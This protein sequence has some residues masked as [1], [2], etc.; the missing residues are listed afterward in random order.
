MQ[1]Q[2]TPR[3]TSAA[4]AALL[5]AVSLVPG[6]SSPRAEAAT[7]TISAP[8]VLVDPRV[9]RRLAVVADLTGSLEHTRIPRVRLADL[10]PLIGANENGGEVILVAVQSDADR[11]ALRLRVPRPPPSPS[12]PSLTGNPVRDLPI[13]RAHSRLLADVARAEDARVAARAAAV[14][15]FRVEAEALQAEPIHGESD[16]LGALG[17]IARALHEPAP[18]GWRPRLAE[19]REVLARLLDRGAVQ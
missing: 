19:V 17:R 12:L 7:E 9:P 6:C 13:R 1:T 8:A 15:R 14:A 5:H 4:L 2:P 16:V 18:S 11:P 3:R 10:E